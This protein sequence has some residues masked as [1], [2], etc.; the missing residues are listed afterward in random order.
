MRR[1]LPILLLSLLACWWVM[2]EQGTVSAAGEETAQ[3][4]DYPADAAARAGRVTGVELAWKTADELPADTA[5]QSGTPQPEA[6]DAAAV[7]G[8]RLRLCNVG[9]Y[10]ANFMAFGSPAPQFFHYNLT[11]ACELPLVARHPDTGADI[12][13]VAE[14]WAVAGKVIRFRLNPAARYSN[15]RPVRAGDYVLGALLRAE[16]GTAEH[17]T[18]CRE[19]VH[20]GAY[21]DSVVELELR[22]A[23]ADAAT[24]AALLHAA[25]PAFYAEFGSDYRTRYAQRMAPT[26]GAYT[27][28][29]TERGRLIELVQVPH[30]WAADLPH[31]RRR[32]NPAA[33]EHHFL[34]DEAQSWELLQRGKLD[35]LQT[36]HLAAWQ[37]R[38]AAAGDTS[39]LLFESYA[40]EYPLPPYGIAFNTERLSNPA[41]RR[42]L[43]HA[44]DMRKAVTVLFRGEVEPLRTFT[45][46][47]GELS[48]TDTPQRGYDPA[49][50]RAAFAEAGYD[51]PAADG[52]LCRADGTRLSV[53]LCYTPSE[54]VSTLVNLL[55]ESARRCGA[56]IVPEP[57]PWQGCDRH[58]REG[59]HELMFWADLPAAPLPDY[60]RWFGAAAVSPFR[61]HDTAL[62]QAIEQY[63]HAAPAD[64]AAAVAAVDACIFRAACW[65]P[66]WQENRA[67]I[68]RRPHV[69]FPT[70]THHLYDLSEEH[71]LWLTPSTR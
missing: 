27:V 34:T 10:P 65:L 67:W 1:F 16:C 28:G 41:L 17:E 71:S 24:A 36:R 68:A 37:E 70:G 9:P 33:I 53:R 46:G 15:G 23:P 49:A 45:S 59:T 66:A 35:L 55:A 64:R 39:P 31:F 48:P 6:G 20:L 62:Q 11:N 51:R 3:A 14:A 69:H 25:E 30:W 57:L 4:A 38:R 7:K 2:R 42:G 40:V 13:A 26:T 21:G 58:L 63:R 5:W 22:R 43:M 50:A 54:K 56:E 44:M 47:Y 32:F 12:P 61:L 8:G 60:D 29:K 52:I 19:A 18:L